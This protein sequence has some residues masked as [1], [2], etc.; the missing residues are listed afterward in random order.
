[1][2]QHGNPNPYAKDKDRVT[3]IH[4]AC[5]KLDWETFEDLIKIGGDPMLPDKDGNTFLH[6]LCMGG[7]KDLEFEFAKMACLQFGQSVKL[8]RNGNQKSPLN[9]LKNF[10]AKIA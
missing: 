1:M 9:I 6:L 3:P 10:E 7:V 8:T 4:V 5:A 2:L